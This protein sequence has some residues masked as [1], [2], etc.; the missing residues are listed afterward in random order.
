[1]SVYEFYRRAS[2]A[3]PPPQKQETLPDKI[4]AQIKKCAEKDIPPEPYACSQCLGY[5]HC[6]RCD[7][8]MRKR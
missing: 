4:H 7:E 6:E 3:Y 2:D 1:M 8:A 5:L